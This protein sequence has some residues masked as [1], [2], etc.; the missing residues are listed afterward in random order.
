MPCG[1]DMVDGMMS[2]PVT[3]TSRTSQRDAHQ[4]NPIESPLQ[5]TVTLERQTNDLDTLAD[6]ARCSVD[7]P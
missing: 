4:H 5:G 3:V 6:D 7:S 1:D 2:R